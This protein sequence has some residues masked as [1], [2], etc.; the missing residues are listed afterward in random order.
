MSETFVIL[1]VYIA[2]GMIIFYL[3]R[4]MERFLVLR[5]LRLC[6]NCPIHLPLNSSREVHMNNHVILRN[7]KEFYSGK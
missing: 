3:G 7:F 5:M 2:V 6:I 1:G 4:Y